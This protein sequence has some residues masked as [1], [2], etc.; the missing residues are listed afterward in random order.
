MEE[1]RSYTSPDFDTLPNELVQV[2]LEKVPQKPP[3]RFI[4]G[5]TEISEDF[6]RGFYRYKE[7]ELFYQGHF[8]GF[9]VTPGVI[10]IETM[11]QIGLV[12]LGIYCLGMHKGDTPPVKIFFTSS[13]VKFQK[14]VLPGDLVWVESKKTFFRLRKLQCEVVMKNQEGHIVC[15]GILSGMMV[16]DK[17]V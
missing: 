2:I 17:S 9:P 13:E 7:N 1:N 5:L 14:V 12:T 16:P 15:S 3:F 10:L 4:D 6:V 11:A 8:P